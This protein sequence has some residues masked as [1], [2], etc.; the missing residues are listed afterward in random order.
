MSTS[1]EATKAAAEP[2]KTVVSEKKRTKPAAKLVKEKKTK[3]SKAKSA[4]IAAHPTYFEVLFTFYMYLYISVRF[5]YNFPFIYD[6][7]QFFLNIERERER[8]N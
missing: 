7:L 3:V 1:V 4:K 8:L 5:I 6:F 2:P